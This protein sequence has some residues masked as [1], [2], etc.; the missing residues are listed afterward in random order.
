MIR[1]L[2]LILL[3][4]VTAPLVEAQTPKGK[5]VTIEADGALSLKGANVKVE[6]SGPVAV[7]GQPIQ[8]N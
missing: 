7:K 8:L 5:E 1:V 3:M 6:G 4:A 2:I